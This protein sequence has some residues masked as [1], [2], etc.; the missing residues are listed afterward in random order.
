[1]TLLLLVRVFSD[2]PAHAK[3]RR[4]NGLPRTEVELM[5]NVLNCLR[6]KDSI[7]YYNLFPPFDTLW[8]MVLHNSDQSP[9]T[10]Q[11]LSK[12]KEHP[13]SLIDFDPYYNHEI[14]G[15]FDA[16]LQKGEDSGI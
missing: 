4:Y 10:Q 2:M 8:H 12:L 14:M 1:I 7:S 11:Q 15:R 16:M 5:N 9:E 6:Y 13:Q 3:K